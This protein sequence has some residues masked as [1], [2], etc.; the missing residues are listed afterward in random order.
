MNRIFTWKSLT[1]GVGLVL[2]AAFICL[3]SGNT[4]MASALIV[5]AVVEGAFH[6]VFVGFSSS[7]SKR[8]VPRVT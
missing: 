4:N 6:A 3:I 5:V 8:H 2:A 7:K 1:I